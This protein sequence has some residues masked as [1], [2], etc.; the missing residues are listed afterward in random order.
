MLALL[1]R[2]AVTARRSSTSSIDDWEVELDR[3][4][5]LSM[6]I[7]SEEVTSRR[8][9]RRRSMSWGPGDFQSW[10]ESGGNRDASFLKSK[11]RTGGGG[12]ITQ[13][14]RD[15]IFAAAGLDKA[16]VLNGGGAG[17]LSEALVP[18]TSARS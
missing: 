17:V 9:V 8:F 10:S 7:S 1:E 4:S 2:P 5:S 14:Q 6:S 3:R 12:P 18:Q 13:A 16:L 15:D 11:T